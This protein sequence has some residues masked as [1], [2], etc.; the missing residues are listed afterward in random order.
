MRGFLS[1]AASLLTLFS[2]TLAISQPEQIYG[3][4]LGSWYLLQ[5]PVLQGLIAN[6]TQVVVRTL[7]A[8]GWCAVGQLGLSFAP[9]TNSRPEWVAMGGQRCDRCQDCIASELYVGCNSP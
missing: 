3:V 4:N 8:T 6:P 1:L 5:S 7:D 9:Q 2:S